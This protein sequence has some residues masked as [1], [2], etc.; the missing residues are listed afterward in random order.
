M[1]D[2]YHS[3][4]IYL[5]FSA[6]IF[7][8][9][10]T[11]MGSIHFHGIN[12]IQDQIKYDMIEDEAKEPYTN[13]YSEINKMNVRNN[14]KNMVEDEE[15]KIGKPN[16]YQDYLDSLYFSIITSCL[17][18]YGDIYPITNISKIFVSIQSFITLSLILF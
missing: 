11:I 5:I 3:K 14:I 17:L 1:K 4:I 18:G 2:K 9:I 10:Y 6:V 16:F 12:K 7:S 15:D 8:I 13:L